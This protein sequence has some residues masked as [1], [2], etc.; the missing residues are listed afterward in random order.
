MAPENTLAAC[1]AAIDAGATA[2]ELDLRA[3]ADG[4]VV[5]IHDPTVARTTDGA[6]RVSRLT[7]KEINSFDAGAWFSSDFAGIHIPTLRD[8]QKHV[9]PRIPCVLHVKGGAQLAR[10]VVA[11]VGSDL[12]PRVTISS[13]RL[14]TLAA[15][16]DT[17]VQRTWISYWRHW[18]GWSRVIAKVAA[19]R[20]IDRVA[21]KGSTVTPAMVAAIHRSA[22]QVRAWGVE[23][24]LDLATHLLAAGVDGMTFNDPAALRAA[25][26]EGTVS[27]A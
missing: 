9:L 6:G 13:S 19:R 22:V 17:G 14:S 10:R 12:R 16:A 26:E 8:I 7:L 24:D 11:A 3:A 27:Q 25:I 1:N 21:P 4:T 2:V 18:L 20:D 5:V 23:A 15:V